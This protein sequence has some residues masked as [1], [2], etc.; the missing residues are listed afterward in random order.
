MFARQILWCELPRINH[1]S[2][3]FMGFNILKYL[4]FHAYVTQNDIYILVE[5]LKSS[6]ALFPYGCTLTI[7]QHDPAN[8]L[9]DADLHFRNSFE[10]KVCPPAEQRTMKRGKKMFRLEGMYF[11]DPVNMN[12]LYVG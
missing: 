11:F 5:I 9:K 8:S 4:V 1:L 3:A 10:T 12:P 7:I 2:W 6:A